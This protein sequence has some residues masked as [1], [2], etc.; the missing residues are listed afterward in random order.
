MHD[1]ADDDSPPDATP[2]QPAL[3][4]VPGLA[5]LDGEEEVNLSAA[6][7]A[8]SRLS[9]GDLALEEALT[10]V[11]TFAVHAVPGADGAGLT[12]IE[13][14]RPNTVVTT[15]DLVRQIEDT[16]Y[17]LGQGPCISAAAEG[18]TMVSG[19]LGADLR[20]PRF[21]GR[22]AR[23]G[24]HSALSVPLLVGDEVVGALNIYAHDKNAF[25]DRAAGLA[26]LFAIPA[27]IG[28]QNAQV[29]DQARRLASRLEHAV[30]TRG[31]IDRAVG[32]II[33]R[34]GV[35]PDEALSRLRR[36]S[37][38]EHRKLTTVA[39]AIVAEAARRARTRHQSSPPPGERPDPTG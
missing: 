3:H 20:W 13:T 6:V 26:E 37:Q 17:S 29:L 9:T 11:A 7:S 36:L 2:S 28:V 1:E 24:V 34:T 5:G 18:R 30:Q 19:S 25:D 21:G 14:D 22:V 32:I 23:L 8:L 33:S 31:T 10:A 27:A 4:L 15:T 38:T 39:D 16:Q 12:L 35:T